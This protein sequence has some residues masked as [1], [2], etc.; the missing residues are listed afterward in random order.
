MKPPQHATTLQYKSAVTQQAVGNSRTARRLALGVCS[1][2]IAFIWLVVLPW[3]AHRS[4]MQARI[5]WLRARQIDPSA[6]VYTEL[7]VMQPILRKLNRP[8]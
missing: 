7:E 6:M 2:A 8:R 5:E 1:C 4:A 3:W